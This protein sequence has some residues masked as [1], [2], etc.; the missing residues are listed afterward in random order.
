MATR[1]VVCILATTLAVLLVSVG[2]GQVQPAEPAAPCS[3]PLTLLANANTYASQFAVG[4]LA[5]GSTNLYFGL[6]AQN[7]IAVLE[8]F[9]PVRFRSALGEWPRAS[10]GTFTA[11][12]VTPI[13]ILWL[14]SGGFSLAFYPVLCTTG[15]KIVTIA[16][17]LHA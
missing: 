11:A 13:G 7:R 14:P 1:L 17:L 2:A 15:N 12:V 4:T 10:A 3:A 9:D 16:F 5:N 6:H 8:N